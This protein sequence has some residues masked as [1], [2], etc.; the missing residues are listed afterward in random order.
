MLTDSMIVPN[1]IKTLFEPIAQIKLTSFETHTH[2][3]NEF[4]TEFPF[5]F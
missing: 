5:Y 3:L 1:P 2:P 4:K